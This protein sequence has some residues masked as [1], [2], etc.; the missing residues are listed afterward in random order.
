MPI[1]DGRRPIIPPGTEG[2]AQSKVIVD[3]KA[4][5]I[6]QILAHRATWLAA[7]GGRGLRHVN[8]SF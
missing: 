3:L 1:D 6:A 5:L 8:H 7:R 2:N 4:A